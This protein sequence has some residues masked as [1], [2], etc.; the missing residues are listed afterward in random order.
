MKQE[1]VAV[2]PTRDVAKGP[3]LPEGCRS[4]AGPNDLTLVT[5]TP[6]KPRSARGLAG[7]LRKV[8]AEA[9]FLRQRRLELLLGFPSLLPAHPGTA[10]PE[11]IDQ[12]VLGNGPVM[13]E[14]LARIADRVQ[15]Q[16]VVSWD[17]ARA[18][19]HFTVPPEA[20]PDFSGQLGRSFAQ[21]LAAPA[22]DAIALPVAEGHLLNLVLLLPRQNAEALDPALQEIDAIWSD[23]FRIRVLG[24][25]PAVSFARLRLQSLARGE[26]AAAAK[27]LGLCP[28]RPPRPEEIEA[29]RK[30]TLRAMAQAGAGEPERVVQAVRR[31]TLCHHLDLAPKS[32]ARAPLASLERDG[33]SLPISSDTPSLARV[34]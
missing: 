31:M 23:G 7:A 3:P 5:G 34:A 11:R 15:V 32:V 9:A 14:G 22:E 2:V 25:G 6:P 27:L 18:G 33:P 19:A 20:L 21:R 8:V 12:L 26:G 28:S 30:S 16:V 4:H 13:A 17:M 10:V 24:P 1:L 29:A